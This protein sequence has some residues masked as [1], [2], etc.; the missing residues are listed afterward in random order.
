MSDNSSGSLLSMEFLFNLIFNVYY[1]QSYNLPVYAV[2]FT[3]FLY[4]YKKF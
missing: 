2:T 3:E 1:F 4:F